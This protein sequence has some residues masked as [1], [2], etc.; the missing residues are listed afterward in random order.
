[1]GSLTHK[2]KVKKKGYSGIEKKF[3]EFSSHVQN[4]IG[5]FCL[6]DYNKSNSIL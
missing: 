3:K 6:L 1:M 4:E 2:N 5:I